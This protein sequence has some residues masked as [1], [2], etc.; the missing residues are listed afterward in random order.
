[1]TLLH[2]DDSYSRRGNFSHLPV[3]SMVLIYSP[4]GTNVW[5]K[6]QEV[7]SVMDRTDVG[8]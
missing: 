3:C 4:D 2:V 6:T 7:V 1:M 5:L 8:S